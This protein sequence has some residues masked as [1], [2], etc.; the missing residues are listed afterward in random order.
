MPSGV[1]AALPQ[2][3]ATPD[4]LEMIRSVVSFGEQLGYE[5][6]WVSDPGLG[7]GASLDPVTMLAFAAALVRQPSTRLGAALFVLPNFSPVRLAQETAAIDRLS[8]G[9][10]TVGV[11]LGPK[12]QAAVAYERPGTRIDRLVH[13]VEVLRAI[14]GGRPVEFTEGGR[15]TTVDHIAPGPEQAGGP[16]LWMGG[17][18]PEALR[19]IAESADGFIG[20]GAAGF[21]RFLTHLATLRTHLDEPAAFPVAKRVYVGWTRGSAENVELCHHWMGRIYRNPDLA[22]TVCLMRGPG[23]CAEQVEALHQAGCNHVIIHPLFDH[24]R[25]L[26]QLAERL[27]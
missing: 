10:L 25:H 1:E 19:R 3:V 16:P 26:E 4:D 14:W 9:R 13:G 6:F 23:E 12:N 17:S 15:T 22:E 21:D 5:G 2:E 24:D 20:A 18:S 27:R 8:G 7:H 11:G